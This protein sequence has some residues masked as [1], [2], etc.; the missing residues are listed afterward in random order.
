MIRKIFIFLFACALFFGAIYVIYLQ[1]FVTG[2]LTGTALM[3]CSVFGFAGA[4]IF[5]SEFIH[6]IFTSKDKD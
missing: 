1:I 2:V 6:P 4:S 5:Y 3:A